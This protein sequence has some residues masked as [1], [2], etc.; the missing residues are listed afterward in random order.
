MASELVASSLEYH[1]LWLPPVFSMSQFVPPTA[2]QSCIILLHKL[3]VLIGHRFE[4]EIKCY[5]GAIC[6]LQPLQ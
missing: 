4:G 5:Y 1:T 3:Q 6:R 2:V